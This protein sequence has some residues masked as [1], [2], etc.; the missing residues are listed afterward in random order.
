MNKGATAN[1]V[2]D[3]DRF[4]H[5]KILY[6]G[7]LGILFLA[8]AL[9]SLCIGPTNL[10]VTE[11]LDILFHKDDTWNSYVV[12][13]L[14]LHRIVAAIIAGVALGSA[15]AV[16]QCV[17]RNPLG[18]PFTLGISNAAAFGAALGI[19]ILGGGTILGQSVATPQVDNPYIV[20]IS[21]FVMAMLSAGVIVLLVRITHSSPE[22]MVLAGMALSSIFSAGL[23]F[24]Q[25]IANDTALS[26]IVFWQ[27]GSLSKATWGDL[28]L[29]AMVVAI[30][31]LYF[32]SKRWDYNAM[33]TGEDIA[34]GLGIN[35]GSTRVLGMVL[36]SVS[37]AVVVSFMG[38][39][40]FIGLLGPHMARWVF[41]NDNR[42]VI[43][44][45]MLIGSTILMVADCIGQN[46]FSFVLPVG[47]LT[48][49]IGGPLFIYILIRRYRERC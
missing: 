36:A 28:T 29:T 31:S 48:S 26:A 22:M 40:G 47:I 20:T 16:M 45:S 4:I 39:I 25:Y 8:V 35:V 34:L 32:L 30:V 13:D 49:F 12:W 37:T 17:L 3:Y 44:A 14:R 46:A 9:I 21:A 23:A 38:V 10:S 15:G 42:Y 6:L 43:P 1:G 2:K 41:G 7:I 18:S 24:L 11:V 5:R 27:F 19:I 33:D